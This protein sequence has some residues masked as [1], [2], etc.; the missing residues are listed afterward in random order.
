MSGEGEGERTSSK[1]TI[2]LVETSDAVL[3]PQT[4]STCREVGV[5]TVEWN[6]D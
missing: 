1:K 4:T 3:G 2:V 6:G 5:A